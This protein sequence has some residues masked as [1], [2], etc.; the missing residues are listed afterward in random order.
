LNNEIGSAHRG[1]GII[2]EPS[3]YI[4]R[5]A[6]GERSDNPERLRRQRNRQEIAIDQ[7]DLPIGAN[8]LP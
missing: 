1:G 3:Q 5:P 7:A 6:E 8:A 4:G 2:E